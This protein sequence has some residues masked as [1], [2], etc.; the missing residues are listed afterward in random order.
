MYFLFKICLIFTLFLP[1]LWFNSAFAQAEYPAAI[2]SYIKLNENAKLIKDAKISR[3]IEI[4]NIDGR[5]DTVKVSYYDKDGYIISELSKIDTSSGKT[6]E[7]INQKLYFFYN[8]NKLLSD[9]IDSTYSMA[10]RY[11]L[12]YDELYNL[13]D[14]EL[15]INNKLVQKNSFEYDDL[16]RMIEAVTKDIIHECKNVVNYKY[17]SYNNLVLIIENNKCVPV[18]NKPVETKYNYTYDKDY[19]ILEK[20][21]NTP[22]GKFKT[23]NFTYTTEGKPAS[24]YEL[25]TDG[26]YI[27]K[28]YIYDKNT[29]KVQT[30]D[31]KGELFSSSELIIEFDKFGNRI[32]EQ[33]FDNNGKQLYSYKFYYSYY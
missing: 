12:K 4:L 9:K 5:E 14:D 6:N 29:V 26:S 27:N 10:K 21:T 18:S 24:S 19:R 16:S 8:N 3:C 2:K 22:N 15:F 13:T 28:K 23:E 32:Q 20:K 1:F 31:V 7:F 33:Y 17:D 11:R 25:N 30:T